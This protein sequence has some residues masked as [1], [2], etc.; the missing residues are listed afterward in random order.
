MMVL[1]IY[2]LLDGRIG[3]GDREGNEDSCG[4]IEGDTDLGLPTAS[5]SCGCI[6]ACILLIPTF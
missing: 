2:E 3:D 6:Y 4:E 5:I 1:Y